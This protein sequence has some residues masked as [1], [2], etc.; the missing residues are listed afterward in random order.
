MKYR[1]VNLT[2]SSLETLTHCYQ[3]HPK[4]HVRQR[5]FA[6]L[7]SDEGY[8]IPAIAALLKTRTRT[9][10]TWLDRWESMGLSG[11]MIQPGR[12]VKARL[13]IQDEA[14]VELVK[15]KQKSM[16]EIFLR[17]DKR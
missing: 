12:G 10:Y 16:L 13:S 8:R 14:V 4:H 5:C 17:Q 6:L 3:H 11:L 9:I 2:S 15:K 1:Y 7:L